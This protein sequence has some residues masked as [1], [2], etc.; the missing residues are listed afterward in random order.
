MVLLTG[1]TNFI[2]HSKL[3]CSP[4]EDGFCDIPLNFRFSHNQNLP[5][6]VYDYTSETWNVTR[7]ITVRVLSSSFPWRSHILVPP[8][9]HWGG[10]CDYATDMWW[11]NCSNARGKTIW[12][13]LADTSNYTLPFLETNLLTNWGFNSILKFSH[14]FLWYPPKPSGGNIW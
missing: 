9:S 2:N 14:G 8:K 13:L 7:W 6:W 1:A 3:P 10:T 11:K 4:L 12:K 5:G